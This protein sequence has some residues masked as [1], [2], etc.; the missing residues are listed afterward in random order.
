MGKKQVKILGFI[1]LQ[2]KLILGFILLFTELRCID[3]M[4]YIERILRIL[5]CI[6]NKNIFKNKFLQIISFVS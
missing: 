3:D 1:W 2:Y 4:F 5:R 6:G